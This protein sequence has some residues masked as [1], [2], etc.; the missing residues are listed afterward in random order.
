[1]ADSTVRVNFVGDAKSLDKTIDSSDKKLSGFSGAV[2]KYS[3]QIKLG[4]AAAGVGAVVF[5]GNAVDAATDLGESVNAV[6]KIFGTSAKAITDWGEENANAFGLTRSAFNQLATPLGAMLK[7]SGI[8]IDQVADSTITLTKR[9]ADMA[10]VF[11]TDVNVALEAIQAGLRGESDP[12]EKFGVGL[13]AAKVEAQAMA[14]TGK[15]VASSLTDQEKMLA[16]VNL[17]L[18]QTVDVEGD[19][20]ETSDQLANAT[21]NKNARFG[22]L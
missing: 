3:T 13:N 19:Y 2:S 16:R 1:M 10:S 14:D 22:E 12:L 21:R 8:A 7:N 9:A 18:A 5:A 17:I 20:A 6:N 15:T 11:N 4:F